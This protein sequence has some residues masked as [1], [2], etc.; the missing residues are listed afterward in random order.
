MRSHRRPRRRTQM[1]TD[2]GLTWESRDSKVLYLIRE[3]TMAGLE[4]ARVRGRHGG[5]PRALDDDKAKLARR[6]KAEGD[7][8]VGEICSMLGVGRSTL[9]RYLKER[10]NGP[11]AAG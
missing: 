10:G 9:Y 7:H 8:S 5:R 6:L 3:R 2:V 1:P 4:A 11:H